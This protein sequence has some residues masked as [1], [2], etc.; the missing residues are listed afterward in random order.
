MK[1]YTIKQLAEGLDSGKWTSVDL[2]HMYLERIEAIDQ[3][4]LELNSIAQVNPDVYAIARQR[5]EERNSK[6]PRSILHGIPL[7][8]KDNINTKDKQ[9]TTAGSLALANFIAP[10]EAHIVTLL[11]Q[12]GA[13]ILGK[14]NLSEFAYFMSFGDMPSGYGS[15][16]G[17]VKSPYSEKI[18]PLG[19]STGSAVA[20]A[21]NLIPIAI[22]TETNGSLTAPAQNN[23]IV[24]IK[25][26]LGLVSRTGIIPISHLQDTAGPLTRTVAD[27]AI[28][29]E[30]IVGK[31]PADKATLLRK[32][33]DYHFSKT[34]DQPI[35][36]LTVGFLTFDNIAYEEEEIRI[37]KKAMQILE[38]KAKAIKQVH[39][40]HPQM[41]NHKTLIYEFKADINHYFH[42]V[43][44]SSPISSLKELIEFNKKDPKRCLKYGQ[45]IF[46]AAEETSGT[47]TEQEYVETRKQLLE[48]AN[49][50]NRIMEQEGIDVLVMNRRTSHAPIAGN[51]VAAVPA[52]ALVDDIPRSLF[53]VAKNF[54]D[55]YCLQVAYQYEQ[56]TKY[57]IPP[58][59]SE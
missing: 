4:G 44:E 59:L 42:T 23:S 29:L 11:E 14:A 8:L 37:F 53:F 43:Q 6:G 5:D 15:R 47:L 13:I 27:A 35:D 56:A 48:D 36:Q 3:N 31:D 21:A 26:T 55:Q 30:A 33:K 39:L 49:A 58:T 45:S 17:Q 18:D 12:S 40:E 34:Y 46:E 32:E 50:F 10:Y 52:K 57:R 41:P 20:V 54:D 24:T 16:F 7:V 19:S 1:E 28:L 25:P 38:P 2:V 22:G 51:P 9:N